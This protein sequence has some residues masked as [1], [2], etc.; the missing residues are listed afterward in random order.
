MTLIRHSVGRKEYFFC[1]NQCLDEFTAP[2]KKL[3]KLKRQA[4][5][6][7][8]RKLESSKGRSRTNLE[9]EN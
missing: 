4:A 1:S 5:I 6:N 2:E 3:K 9:H 8:G 7:I